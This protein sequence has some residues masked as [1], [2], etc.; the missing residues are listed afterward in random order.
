MQRRRRPRGRGRGCSAQRMCASRS[1]P[2]GQGRQIWP[3]CMWPARTRSNAPGGQPVE[4][5]PGSGRAGCAG[6]RSASTSS[7]GL[8]AAPAE[9]ARVDAGD[10]DAAA[11]QL[12]RRAPRPTS[13]V[14]GARSADGGRLRERVAG[15]G[16]VV[17]AEHRE[18]ARQPR[19]QRAQLRLA[20]AAARRRS[21][22]MQ[23]SGRAAR[24][25]TQSTAR[26]TA[27]RAARGHAEVEVGE[28]RDPQPVELRRQA[29]QRARRSVSQPHPAGLE[30]APRRARRAAAAAAERDQIRLRLRAS[31]RPA[32]P[33]RRGA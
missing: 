13:S 25:P 16:E 1:F 31:R 20:R 18:A 5:R 7:L 32:R 28:V 14:A 30:P 33:R 10:L 9:R 4:R 24:S 11:A 17:V 2:P 23:T 22:V 26:S 12:D 27:A 6:R 29:R 19:E 8:R 3:S 21:P 15:D